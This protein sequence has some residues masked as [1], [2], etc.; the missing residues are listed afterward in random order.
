M[1]ARRASQGLVAEPWRHSVGSALPRTT[2][3]RLARQ[4]EQE[5]DATSATGPRQGQY[6]SRLAKQLRHSQ[7][8]SPAKSDQECTTP[9]GPGVAQ[10]RGRQAASRRSVLVCSPR[11]FRS[12]NPD[13]YSAARVSPTSPVASSLRYGSRSALA[14]S[15]GRD[16]QSGRRS[17]LATMPKMWRQRAF[18]AVRDGNSLRRHETSP[19]SLPGS[20]DVTRPRCEDV[21]LRRSRTVRDASPLHCVPRRCNSGL[22][23]YATQTP[24]ARTHRA[25]CCR[26]AAC[27]AGA[28]PDTELRCA[29][30]NPVRR[31]LHRDT[32]SVQH[33]D[34]CVGEPCLRHEVC[35]SNPSKNVAAMLQR[36]IA[37]K[38]RSRTRT[39]C[40]DAD[41]RAR[42]ADQKHDRTTCCRDASALFA[43]S[44]LRGTA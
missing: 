38:R 28:S 40:D 12:T 26:R 41:Q 43:S 37:I 39:H 24:E 33:L 4:L 32:C 29:E 31:K 34:R 22:L 27:F 3:P 11:K 18:G 7:P 8:W 35:T 13:S 36:T 44:L 6:G 14:S 10:Q 30:L 20:S 2:S 42:P 21:L 19:W 17:R 15:I 5:R 25:L 9:P 23:C 16:Q 1:A